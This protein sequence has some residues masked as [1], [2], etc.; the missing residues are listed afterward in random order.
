MS[1]VKRYNGYKLKTGDTGPDL[2]AQLIKDTGAPRDLS[3]VSDVV[4]VL[5]EAN[6]PKEIVN[7][8]TSRN[9]T[10]GGDNGDGS[11][12]Y[13]EYAWQSSDTETART[14]V[15]EVIVIPSASEQETYPN[16][17]TFEVYV[18]EGLYNGGWIQSQ[19]PKRWYQ[20]ASRTLRKCI[21]TLNG[22]K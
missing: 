21:S 6:S 11:N 2:R 15:G 4:I 5:E 10:I 22:M 7:D 3:S 14:L 18:E 19:F 17:G 12:G 8:D 1:Q 9:V 16:R 20:E 13:V